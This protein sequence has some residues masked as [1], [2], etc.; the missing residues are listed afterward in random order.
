MTPA[1]YG[2]TKGRWII[3]Q[4]GKDGTGWSLPPFA[5]DT[6]AVRLPDRPHW[7]GWTRPNTTSSDP[8]HFYDFATEVVDFKSKH[9]VGG[10]IHFGNTAQACSA[11][12]PSNLV[13]RYSRRSRLLSLQR[14][15]GFSYTYDRPVDAQVLKSLWRFVSA[16]NGK[17]N[18]AVS[19]GWIGAAERNTGSSSPVLL[20]PY[21]VDTTV[22]QDLVLADSIPFQLDQANLPNGSPCAGINRRGVVNERVIR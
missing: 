15:D 4:P 13:L 17:R 7:G 6:S 16:D 19:I 8:H 11:L 22:G 10:G 20:D 3:P 12:D 18:M 5:P 9:S 1:A 21:L 2:S 14:P